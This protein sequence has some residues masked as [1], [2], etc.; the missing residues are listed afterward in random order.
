[1]IPNYV[2]AIVV[3]IIVCFVLTGF[4]INSTTEQ[5]DDT[6]I[7]ENTVVL[8]E[9]KTEEIILTQTTNENS[10]YDILDPDREELIIVLSKMLYGEARDC[11]QTEQAAVIWCAFNIAE[12]R[13]E[14]PTYRDIINSTIRKGTFY[15]Y[16]PNNPLRDD[17]LYIVKD[18]LERWELE[19][20]NPELDVKRVL[21]KDYLYFCG[22]GTHNYFRNKY[23]GDYDIWDW[24]LESPYESPINLFFCGPSCFS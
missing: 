7:I 12:D 14:N 22:D 16:N 20:S 19:Q 10:S 4:A 8:V 6:A 3:Y 1:M 17:H 23:K 2:K 18:V 15:G 13:Y 11:S 24:S 5:L 9:P 21:P